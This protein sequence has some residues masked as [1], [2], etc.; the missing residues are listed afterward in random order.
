[1]IFNGIKAL[2]FS[3]G[4]MVTKIRYYLGVKAQ[5]RLPEL[6]LLKMG[7]MLIV[8]GFATMFFLRIWQLSNNAIDAWDHGLADGFVLLKI[9]FVPLKVAIAMM[10]FSLVIL[11]GRWSASRIARHQ[12][13]RGVPDTQVAMASIVTYL[14]FALALLFSLLVSGVDFTGLAIVAGALS[15][16]AGLGLQ[17]AVN[18]FVS[19]LILLIEKP[20]KPGDRVI[21]GDKEGFVKKVSIRSTRITTLAHSDIIFP[22]ADLVSK[23]VTNFTFRDRYWRLS[24]T[25]GVAYGSDIHLV[26]KILL[27]IGHQHPEVI[28]EGEPS[29]LPRVLFRSFGE[30]ALQ[31]ELWCVVKDV[32]LKS[33]VQSDLNFAIDAAFRE[34]NISIAFPQRDL[35]IKGLEGLRSLD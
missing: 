14:F 20:I 10:I 1:L 35:H 4:P 34:H 6:W 30:S 24:C 28:I 8:L 21:I 31:F 26:K 27:D 15:V 11:I 9:H 29:L 19:G 2:D 25:V 17:G 22:N 12:Q 13:F 23:E 33:I 7:L 16:G 5:R 18:N 3:T 32:N